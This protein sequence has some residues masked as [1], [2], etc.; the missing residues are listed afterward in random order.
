MRGKIPVLCVFLCFS[1]AYL[2]AFPA[3]LGAKEADANKVSVLYTGDPFPGVT[4]YNSMQEDAF[5]TVTPIQACSMHYA[6]ITT[7]DIYKSMRV[8][9]PRSY[10]DYVD[11]YNV[12]ILSDSNKGVFTTEQIQWLRDGVI[13]G[14]I[15]SSWLEAWRASGGT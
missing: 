1:A 3:I 15:V 2:I 12:M 8:Y 11:R 4:P 7:D 10:R 13:D 5:I 6:G 14:G 9:M